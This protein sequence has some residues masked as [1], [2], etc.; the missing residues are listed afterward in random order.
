M[1]IFRNLPVRR[2]LI[3]IIMLTS[4]F[5]LLMASAAFVIKDLVIFR[6]SIQHYLTS[7]TQVIGMNS[8]GALLFN[9]TNTAENNL[10]SL[11][12]MPYVFSACIY[13]KQGMPFATYYQGDKEN[14][15]SPPEYQKI[16]RYLNDQ[17]KKR[18]RRKHDTCHYYSEGDYLFFFDHIF[19]DNEIIGTV[20]IQYNKK[21][22][23]AGMKHG[24]F[25]FAVILIVSLFISLALSNY[26]QKFISAPILRLVQTAKNISQKRDYTI[27]AEKCSLYQDEIGA[28][29]DGFNEMVAEIEAQAN[30]IVR[31]REHLEEQIALRTVELA[32]VNKGLRQTVQELKDAKEAAEVANR[33][34]SEFLANMSHEIRTPMNAV[35]GFAELLTSMITD[36]KQRSYIESIRSSGKS[37]LTLINDILDLSKIEARKM[38]LHYEPVNPISIFREIQDIFSLKMAEKGLEFIIEI[39]PDIPESL[40]LD[41]VRLRQIIFNLIGNAVK[42]TDTGHIKLIV[43]NICNNNDRSSLDLII[44]VEDTGIG[45]PAESKEKIFEAFK[46]KDGQNTKQYGGTGLGLTITKRL[47]E[48]MGGEISVQSES[49]KGS[50]FEIILYNVALAVTLPKSETEK[51]FEYENIVFEEATVLVVDDIDTNRVL[52]EEFFRDTP[53][54]FIGAENGERAIIMA[55]HYHPDVIL[56]DL[57]MPLMDGHEATHRIRNDNE[58]KDTVI[59]ALTAS[60]MK[61]EKEKSL[62]SGFDGYLIKPVRKTDL[63]KEL[64]RFIRHSEIPHPSAATK[65]C[66]SFPK[67]GAE[68]GQTE[69]NK[70]I[71][72]EAIEKIPEII[73][74]LES[75]LTE[76]WKTAKQNGFFNEI[77]AFGNQIREMGETYSLAILRQYGEDLINHVSSFDIEQMNITLNNY[78][79]LIEKIKSL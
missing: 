11:R 43:E 19:F 79:Q 41:E 2:K 69:K 67:S 7:L 63:F 13:D 24:G 29:I 30:E 53:I 70:E 5:T 25:I 46:Q 14:S 51:K 26:L 22:I 15:F 9:D 78:P 52:V 27:R 23:F 72:A 4:S 36:K 12:A 35:L 34:K 62:Q 3:M 48:M 10:A 39:A 18:E 65:E 45:I 47:V 66:I 68:T 42:F 75:D 20:C 44:A 49:G 33:A 50:R 16:I 28:L 73:E 54:Q 58:L 17:D 8:V 56:M 31:H 74:K 40:L 21:E 60:G 1:K 71:S 59:I 38:E 64:A 37:L 76:I 32:D 6:K 57:R 77:E 55:K 61:E